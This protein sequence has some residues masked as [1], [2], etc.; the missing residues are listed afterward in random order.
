[1]SQDELH[2]LAQG[3]TPQNVSVPNTL[4]GLLAWGFMRFGTN[5]M[6]MMIGV[7]ALGYALSG[8]YA[9]LSRANGTV[10]EIVRG[11]TAAT[12]KLASTLAEL[13]KQV[14]NNTR[15]IAE[16]RLQKATNRQ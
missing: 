13:A 9:D 14:E 2:A 15:A 6:I 12:E 3:D 1:M 11:Q 16:D 10:L 7:C 8:I 4:A 5:V